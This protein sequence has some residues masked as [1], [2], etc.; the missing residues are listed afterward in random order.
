MSDSC[1]AYESLASGGDASKGL[2]HGVAFRWVGVG[3]GLGAGLDGLR[4]VVVYSALA[5]CLELVLA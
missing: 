3:A 4:G 1:T 5:D 2:L